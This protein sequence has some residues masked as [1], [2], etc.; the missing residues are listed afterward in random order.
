[1]SI[2]GRADKGQP[3]LTA[4]QDWRA[5]QACQVTHFLNGSALL[6]RL[7]EVRGSNFKT[8][9]DSVSDDLEELSR[10][11]IEL[12]AVLSGDPSKE[13]WA[14]AR[15]LTRSAVMQTTRVTFSVGELNAAARS[16]KR[17]RPATP[18]LSS[19]GDDDDEDDEKDM[20][21]PAER[22]ADDEAWDYAF[23]PGEQLAH[24]DPKYEAAG[25]SSGE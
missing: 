24:W 11:H 2:S 9:G 6:P 21:T 4:L 22:Q 18:P 8:M 19:D 23:P 20:R 17:A 7:I 10:L 5:A 12:T 1:M 3:Q 14:K 13:A 25:R 15:A 16:V